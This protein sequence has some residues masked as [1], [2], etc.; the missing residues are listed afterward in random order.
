MT[1]W[2]HATPKHATHDFKKSC[3]SLRH[4][5]W[6]RIASDR[7]TVEEM[8]L[9]EVCFTGRRRSNIVRHMASR[10][11]HDEA[12][13]SHNSAGACRRWHGSRP[14]GIERAIG[15]VGCEAGVQVGAA[16]PSETTTAGTGR[17][18]AP[19]RGHGKAADSTSDG[20]RA[21][22]QEAEAAREGVLRRH[23]C[24]LC[25]AARVTATRSGGGAAARQDRDALGDLGLDTL[26]LCP[27]MPVELPARV[28]CL[29]RLDSQA[30]HGP[31]Q[32]HRLL[33][34]QVACRAEPSVLVLLREAGHDDGEDA[35][36]E[37]REEEVHT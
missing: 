6:Q 31:A 23:R 5:V 37:Y 20:Q 26:L 17:I 8:G 36:N 34:Q 10:S 19:A 24:L 30:M 29:G 32:T 14:L 2:A 1:A 27:L 9:R 21:R 33:A 13:P 4:R 11:F 18:G 35:S 12:A 7:A 28:L 16:T 22:A 3:T 25:A 15:L